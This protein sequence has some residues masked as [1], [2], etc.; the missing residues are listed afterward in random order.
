MLGI[1]P[2]PKL[3]LIAALAAVGVLAVTA[4]ATNALSPE[5]KASRTPIPGVQPRDESQAAAI[6]RSTYIPQPSASIYPLRDSAEVARNILSDPFFNSVLDGQNRPGPEFDPRVVERP[7]PLAP[8]Y[9]RALVTGGWDE[10]LVPVVS[11]GRIVGL[12]TVPI[13]RD[14]QGA[15]G[16]YRRW[17]AP[18]FPSV[19][20]TEARGRASLSTDP[21]VAAELVWATVYQSGGA[22]ADERTPFWRLVRQSGTEFYLFESGDLRLASDVKIRGIP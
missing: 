6:A 1:K 21:V 3:G 7:T 5:S 12:F 22:S 13:V 17:I 8:V 4:A 19:V 11:G 16:S 15:V 9:V 14:G 18:T 20:E 2:T 10:Y